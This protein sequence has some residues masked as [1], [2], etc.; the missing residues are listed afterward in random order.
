MGLEQQAVEYQQ[1]AGRV[2]GHALNVPE[3]FPIRAGHGAEPVE[4][5]EPGFQDSV[6][7]RELDD[8]LGGR[9][10]GWEQARGPR[11]GAGAVPASGSRPSCGISAVPP[12]S[13][14]SFRDSAALI[15]A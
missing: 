13:R 14:S 7:G 15:P 3:L 10:G 12:G 5:L 6:L 4:F 2:E 11:N 8:L 1:V 9:G